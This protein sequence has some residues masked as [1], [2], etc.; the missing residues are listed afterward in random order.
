MQ[1]VLSERYFA[2]GDPAPLGG[3]PHHGPDA[4]EG[5]VAVHPVQDEHDG[6]IDAVGLRDVHGSRG[7]V[8]VRRK[9]PAGSPHPKRSVCAHPR[10]LSYPPRRRS[11]AFID[12]GGCVSGGV[13]ND[14]T[15]PNEQRGGPVARV[16]ALAVFIV[17]N[18]RACAPSSSRAQLA[19]SPIHPSVKH[20]RLRLLTEEDG[21]G[22]EGA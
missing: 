20:A 21:M 9:G 2:N 12:V 13:R 17:P 1:P 5:G 15:R 8:A 16:Y 22:G 11:P 3:R 18:L 7:I 4:T 14:A 10:N 6:P 19:V